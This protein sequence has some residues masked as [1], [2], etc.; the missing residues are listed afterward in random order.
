M[1]VGI[2][3]VC[4]FIKSDMMFNVKKK[5]MKG[6]KVRWDGVIKEKPCSRNKEMP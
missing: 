1:G 3:G 5:K 6:E 2:V 4:F